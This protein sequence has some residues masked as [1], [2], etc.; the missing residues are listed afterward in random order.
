[1]ELVE[2]YEY[3]Q[4]YSKIIQW[5]KFGFNFKNTI[6]IR[7]ELRKQNAWKMSLIFF[8]ENYKNGLDFNILSAVW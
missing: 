2:N 1:M 5:Q 6:S 7:D 4:S 3:C 8:L